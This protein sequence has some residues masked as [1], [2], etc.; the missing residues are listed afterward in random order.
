MAWDAVVS[1]QVA[2]CL[3]PE[4]LDAI[5][6]SAWSDD[7]GLAVTDTVVTKAGNVEHVV[8]GQGIGKDDGIQ[9]YLG[10]HYG[11]DRFL[12]SVWDHLRVDAPTAFEDTKDGNFAS[13]STSPLSLAGATEIAFVDFDLAADRR[14]ILHLGS[15]DVAQAVIEQDCGV[16]VDANQLGRAAGGWP[17]A[18]FPSL[19]SSNAVGAS[20]RR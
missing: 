5:D 17:L 20:T 13:G 8:S 12:G 19:V 10:F 15:D 2:L 3:V 16:L 11:Q 14:C 1:A 6:V 9:L 18:K 7:E 4:I